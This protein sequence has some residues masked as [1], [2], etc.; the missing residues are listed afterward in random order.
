MHHRIEAE[1]VSELI[2]SARR[3][4]ERRNRASIATM[5]SRQERVQR[6]LAAI[7]APTWRAIRG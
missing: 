2:N 6:R 5:N 3:Y 4:G 1:Q 7:L